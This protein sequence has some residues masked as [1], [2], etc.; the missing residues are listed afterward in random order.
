MRWGTWLL[1]FAA[2]GCAAA[3][4]TDSP[5]SVYRAALDAPQDSRSM[6]SGCRLVKAT[7]PVSLSELELEGQEDPYHAQK[8]EAADSGANALLVLSKIAVARRNVECPPALKITDCPPS[9]GAWYRVAFESYT[10]TPRPCSRS[11][12][13]PS[14]PNSETP[15][16]QPGRGRPVKWA[17]LP[18]LCLESLSF[19]ENTPLSGWGCLVQALPVRRA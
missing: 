6:P 1:L 17:S 2:S 12:S 8:K 3:I 16:R 9:S 10:C 18:S 19:R 7:Q 11:R 4:K 5:V 13:L 15:F 14:H